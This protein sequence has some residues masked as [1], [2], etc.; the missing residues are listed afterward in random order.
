MGILIILT[1]LTHEPMEY[2]SIDLLTCIF[3]SLFH[4][5]L[6]FW[7]IGLILYTETL[8]NLFI[9]VESLAFFYI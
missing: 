7:C 9:L 1:I 3:F 2:L 8:M 4:Q 5:S 6:C